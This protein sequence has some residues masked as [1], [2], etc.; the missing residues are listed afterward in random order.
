M[1]GVLSIN[2]GYSDEHFV[3]CEFIQ[4]KRRYRTCL[5]LSFYPE[6]AK[7]TPNFDYWTDALARATNIQ[8]FSS[9]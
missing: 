7:H 5:R 3:S 2:L 4:A 8:R 9:K 1:A 6:G